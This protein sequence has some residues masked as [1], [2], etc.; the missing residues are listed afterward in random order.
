MNSWVDLLLA[1]RADKFPEYNYGLT[2][3]LIVGAC[4]IP[5]AKKFTNKESAYK[6]TQQ[7]FNEMKSYN[8]KGLIVQSTYCD[9]HK[10]AVFNLVDTEW[11]ENSIN[12]T[13]DELWDRYGKEI[14]EG[15]FNIT[16]S[17]YEKI[18]EIY[19]AE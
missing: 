16:D 13:F 7:I 15:N 14:T 1:F 4:Q 3:K 10:G 12:V 17:D 9:I 11:K 2:P 5:I 8:V 18:K 19:H 6:A